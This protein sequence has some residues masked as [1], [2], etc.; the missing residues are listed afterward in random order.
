MK[1]TRQMHLATKLYLCFTF[2]LLISSYRVRNNSH[3][4]L[5]GSITAA[6]SY[7][8]GDIDNGCHILTFF[9]ISV[10]HSTLSRQMNKL[11]H[12]PT[13]YKNMNYLTSTK[14]FSFTDLDEFQ[15]K[16]WASFLIY[17][18]SQKTPFINSQDKVLCTDLSQLLPCYS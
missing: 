1:W 15:H 3:F 16:K 12:L 13:F 9:G 2:F 17:D 11:S 18:N 7:S 4:P 5:L 8:V 14:W 10:G 6:S